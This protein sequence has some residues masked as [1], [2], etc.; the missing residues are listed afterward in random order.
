MDRLY[1][2]NAQLKARSEQLED[3]N[4]NLEA[5]LKEVMEAVKKYGMRATEDGDGEEM[6]KGQREIQEMQFP[7]IERMLAVSKPFS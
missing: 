3:E 5:G 6:E 4:K 1:S 7:S 2:D